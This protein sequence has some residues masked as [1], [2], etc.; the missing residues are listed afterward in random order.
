MKTTGFGVYAKQ[1][2]WVEDDLASLGEQIII[3]KVVG[4]LMRGCTADSFLALMLESGGR[5]FIP[6]RGD[7]HH[8]CMWWETIIT[9]ELRISVET[10]LSITRIHLPRHDPWPGGCHCEDHNV[11]PHGQ[12]RLVYKPPLS[13]REEFHC[14]VLR[15]GTCRQVC[16]YRRTR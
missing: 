11:I 8:D 7:A 2:T 9:N 6:S 16:N 12:W 1:A 10:K 4:K 3:D 14:C 13:F 5:D 15:L